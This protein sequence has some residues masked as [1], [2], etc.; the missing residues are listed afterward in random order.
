MHCAGEERFSY[1]EEKF[2]AHMQGSLWR[3]FSSQEPTEVRHSLSQSSLLP[4]P[5][6]PLFPFLFNPLPPF[7]PSSSIMSDDPG[8]HLR[9]PRLGST[10]VL[11]SLR[12]VRQVLGLAQA[13]ENL[14]D[15][16]LPPRSPWQGLTQGLMRRS[17]AC[18]PGLVSLQGSYRECCLAESRLQVVLSTNFWSL[19]V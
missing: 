16:D 7:P 15:S 13:P 11:A 10:F 4:L 12:R 19:C 9:K 18:I 17:R 5:L 8:S 6:S 2:T 1:E 14:P 3:Y